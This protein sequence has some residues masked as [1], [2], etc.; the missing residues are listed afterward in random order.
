MSEII[1]VIGNMQNPESFEDI[2]CKS[3][4]IIHTAIDYQADSAALDT[5]TVDLFID[6]AKSS[7]QPKILVY[8]S[9]V[10][11]YGNFN[12][13]PLTEQ[14]P[15]D[16]ARAFFWLPEV[17]QEILNSENTNSL[18]I[19][20]GIVYGKGG[21]LTSRWFEGASNGSFIRVVGDGQNHWPMVHVDDLAQGY[22]KAVQSNLDGEIINLV[23]PTHNTVMEMASA[24]A[25]AAGNI[26]QIEFVP[27]DEAVKEM[28]ELAEALAL[29]Q[30]VDA[31][32]AHRLLDW[33]PK[34]K[35]FIP[36]VDIYYRAW[37]ANR[38]KEGA[39]Q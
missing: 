4:V 1:P 5:Q 14:S 37:K 39:N 7:S 31:T 28:G 22:L 27:V 26:R 3:D 8:T 9:G 21:D 12:G 23:D 11:V 20:P 15:V 38:S 32:K 18:V 19:R 33:Q 29:D 36:E 24:A 16:P 25:K 30:I 17:E 34:H 13:Q 6:I 2:A 10:W 35:G